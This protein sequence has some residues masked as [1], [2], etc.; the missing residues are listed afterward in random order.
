LLLVIRVAVSAQ[1]TRMNADTQGVVN[2]HMVKQQLAI[3]SRKG[4]SSTVTY[5]HG[6]FACS[7]LSI[8]RFANS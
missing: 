1:K 6:N 7:L 2:D 8:E 3:R 4:T 5:V